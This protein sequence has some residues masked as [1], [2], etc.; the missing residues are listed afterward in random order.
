MSLPECPLSV[1]FSPPIALTENNTLFLLKPPPVMPENPPI[2]DDPGSPK[3][4]APRRPV[5]LL[6]D[7][8]RLALPPGD[9]VPVAAA[10]V[11]DGPRRAAVAPVIV[12][13]GNINKGRPH[14]GR[15]RGWEISKFCGQTVVVG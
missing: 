14:G 5:P 3:Q 11:D 10:R 8:G 6:V 13:Y 7:R 4:P 15:R 9:E 2:L 12:H 1:Y